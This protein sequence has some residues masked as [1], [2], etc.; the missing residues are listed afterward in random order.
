MGTLAFFQKSLG[1]AGEKDFSGFADNK[2]NDGKADNDEPLNGGERGNAENICERRK[3]DGGRLNERADDNR[4]S[5]CT[6]AEK[7]CFKERQ[8]RAHIDGM[9]NLTKA[10]G[11]KSHG[12]A[13]HD[14]FI[15]EHFASDQKRK[16]GYRADKHSFK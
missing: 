16:N 10:D 12:S 3:N 13:E 11:A 5:H 8:R 9:G 6:V 2:R 15:S 1:L 4:S 7:A 14:I